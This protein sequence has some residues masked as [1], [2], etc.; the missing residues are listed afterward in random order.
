MYHWLIGECKLIGLNM[1]D[2]T[3]SVAAT[4]FCLKVPPSSHNLWHI[5]VLQGY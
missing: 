2:V 1:H 4:L 3:Y 5:W